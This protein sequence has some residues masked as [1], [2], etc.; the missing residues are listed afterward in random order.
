MSRI[1]IVWP[2]FLVLALTLAL[3]TGC[4]VS[5][6]PTPVP[7]PLSTSNLNLIFVVSEDLAYQAP[8]D[9]NPQTANLTNRG[10][11]RS[12]LMGTFL[13]Q[14][15]LGG[16]NVTSI[17][18]V[19]P[20]THLQTA[21]NYPDM[22]SLV[23]IQQFA[24]LNQ[25]SIT[26]QGNTSAANSFPVFASYASGSVPDGVA[27]PVYSCPACQGLD[28]RDQ[29]SDNE[30]LVSGIVQAN[31]PGFYVF[32]APWETV[33][34]LLANINRLE[35]YN[36]TLPA[37]YAGPNNVYA[38]SVA[39]SGSVSLVA[40][41]GNLDPPS[42]YP[43]LPPRAIESASCTGNLHFQVTGGVDGAVFPPG[44][45]TNET[46]YM[47]RHAEAHPTPNWDDGNYVG[48]G[49]WRAL[50]L[51]NALRG[52]IQPNQVYSIDPAVGIPGGD[53]SIPSSYVRPSMTVEPYAIANNLPFNLAASV[54]VFAQNPPQL[55][56]AAS[57]FF[58][59]GGT[60]SNQ[61]LLVGWEHD[62]IPPA[63]NALLAAYQS[64]QTVPDWSNDDYDS[65]W[66]ITLDAQGNL[67]VDTEACEG[68]N[69]AT[70]RIAPPQF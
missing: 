36:L 17:Y 11:Q 61:T 12:L 27:P 51:P 30:A 44:I 52:K 21:N 3:G 7:A 10:L 48:A 69:S 22:V 26:Y 33:S 14:K 45:N 6:Q 38:I 54:A 42:S 15:A 46:V 13:Q 32:S 67:T 31:A 34:A 9:V 39:P 59:T 1:S 40:Y 56:T 43:V 28:F 19:E 66:T 8:G 41:N 24:V 25:A 60:F 64:S 57:D 58:F 70:L 50:D 2:L 37:N 23:T 63:V 49:Q 4:S 47:I 20:M 62:H 55:S 16:S 18:A 68:I 5:S 29:N 53:G 35:N 65:M